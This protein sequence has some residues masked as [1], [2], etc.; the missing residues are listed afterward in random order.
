VKANCVTAM[1]LFNGTGYRAV[2]KCPVLRYLGQ[3]VGGRTARENSG[4][5]SER[6]RAN[7][8]ISTI[9][10]LQLHP[11]RSPSQIFSILRH[12]PSIVKYLFRCHGCLLMIV[13]KETGTM[14]PVT[15]GRFCMNQHVLQERI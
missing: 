15:K 12:Q 5:P 14:I 6:M 11:K 2:S 10:A 8:F 3:A 1:R 4:S 7:R 13:I 9:V